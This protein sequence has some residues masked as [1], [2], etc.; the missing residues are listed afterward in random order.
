ME[1]SENIDVMIEASKTV[2]SNDCRGVVIIEIEKLGD[3]KIYHS[4]S[5]S[6]D[7]LIKA[8]SASM[9]AVTMEMI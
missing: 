8:I 3:Y 1:E 9:Y 6:A 5:I 7:E 2:L 4:E